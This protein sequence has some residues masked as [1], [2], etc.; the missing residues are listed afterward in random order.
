MASETASKTFRDRLEGMEC[1][2]CRDFTVE[3]LAAFATGEPLDWGYQPFEGEL[4]K[5]I[6]TEC[7]KCG[8]DEGS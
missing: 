5:I 3:G 1:P 4:L 6:W 7:T 2:N 8:W